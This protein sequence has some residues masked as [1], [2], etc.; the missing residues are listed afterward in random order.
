M[1]ATWISERSA[2]TEALGAALG[3]AAQPHA[4]IALQGD[5]GAG[6]TTLVRGLGR[7][8]ELTVAISSPTYTLMHTYPGRLEL[9]HF[10]AWMQ[11]REAA[12][13]E[14]GGRE[15]FEAGGVAVVEW[16]ERIASV[17]PTDV[18]WIELGHA[19]APVFDED[20]HPDPEQE[21][22]VRMWSTG[23]ASEALLGTILQAPPK[24]LKIAS[25]S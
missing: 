9:Y 23:P 8:L 18:L 5:L 6:K 2:A 16:A 22:S 24:G 3:R 15:W 13:L 14:G 12:F 4:V 19:T 7:G 20:G 17:L 11:G 10:D 25:K 1:D 21:R